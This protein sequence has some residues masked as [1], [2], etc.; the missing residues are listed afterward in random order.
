MGFLFEEIRR[1]TKRNTLLFLLLFGFLLNVANAGLND[2]LIAHYP[3]DGNAQ[4]VVGGF[5]GTMYST[6]STSDRNS[7]S[8]KALYFNG[9]N[10]WVTLP[11]PEQILGPNPSEY[12]VT[13]WFR[14]SSAH[15]GIIITQY[16]DWVTDHEET[17]ALHLNVV[18]ETM[19][20]YLR[21]QKDMG[22]VV[23]SVDVVNVGAWHHFAITFSK[24][25]GQIQLYVNGNFQGLETGFSPSV[26]YFDTEPLYLGK[27]I[28]KDANSSLFHGSLDDIKIY[29]RVLTDIEIGQSADMSVNLTTGLVSHYSFDG[30][31]QNSAGSY[32]H[33]IEQ[34]GVSY[35][36]GKF[37]QAA[38]FD[39]V[40]DHIKVPFHSALKPSYHSMSFWMKTNQTTWTTPYSSSYGHSS[41]NNSGVE[42]LLNY[43][44]APGE[45]VHDNMTAP[46]GNWGSRSN[47]QV[48]DGN[49]HHI[50]AS[51]DGTSSTIYVD[52]IERGSFNVNDYPQ[53]SAG[54][55]YW[56]APYPPYFMFGYTANTRREANTSYFQGQIDEFRLYS[57]PINANE[58]T[59]LSLDGLVGAIAVKEATPI[60]ETEKSNSE[61]E[62]ANSCFNIKGSPGP[63]TVRSGNYYHTHTDFTLPAQGLPLTITRYYNNQD[64]YA[65]PFGHNWNMDYTAQLVMTEDDNGDAF[66]TVRLGNGVRRKFID[67]GDGTFVAPFGQ[68][69]TLYYDGNYYVFNGECGVGCT[70]KPRKSY[71]FHDLEGSLAAIQDQN[72]TQVTIGYNLDG[73]IETVTDTNGRQITFAYGANGRVSTVSDFD[74]RVWTYSYDLED[75]LT[76]VAD[77]LEQTIQYQYDTNHN[78][79]AIIDALGNTVSTVSYD[80]S[81]RVVQ[82]TDNGGDYN[83]SHDP[84]SKVT[85]K[86]NP[87]AGNFRF[88]Y[89]DNGNI[90]NKVGP[91]GQS[92]NLTWDANVDM[93]SKV[94]GLSVQT[95]Y[96]YYSDHSVASVTRDATGLALTTSYTYDPVT[97]KVAQVTDPQTNTTSYIYDAQGNLLEQHTPIGTTLYEYDIFGNVTKVTDPDGYVTA[98]EYDTNGYMTRE[99]IPGTEPV[100]ETLYT[101]DNRGNL[102]TKTDPEGHTTTYVYDL[103]NQL[104]SVTDPLN[105]VSTFEYD[106]NG[107]MTLMTDALSRQTKFD[108]DLYDRLVTKT[109]DFG[110]SLERQTTYTYDTRGNL[111]TTTDPLNHTTTNAYD[112]LSRLISVTDELS[113]IWV[114]TYDA[115]GN[116]ET[117]TDPNS[118]TTQYLYDALNRLIGV[119]DAESLVTSYTYDGNGRLLTVLNAMSNM[120]T[121]NTYD[122]N[123]RLATSKDALNHTTTTTYTAGGRINTVTDANGNV[124]TYN[125][126][127]LTGRLASIVYGP[128]ART[129]TYV[130]DK[131]GRLLSVSDDQT[132]F[133]VVYTYDANGKVL[134]DTQ[135]GQVISYSYD[136]VGNR[137]TMDV[138]GVGQYQYGYDTLNR[139]SSILNPKA[140]QTTFDYNAADLRTGI[141]YA[142]GFSTTYAFDEVNRLTS[143][144]HTSDLGG[145]V[146][147][148]AYTYDA[149]NNRQSETDHLGNTVTYTYDKTYKLLSAV[150]PGETISFIYDAVGNRLSRTDNTET[151]TYTYDDADRLTNVDHPDGSNT[152]YTWDSNGNLQTTY[153]T[154]IGTPTNFY[155]S[156]DYNYDSK[157]QLIQITYDGAS[158]VDFRYDP[159]GRRLSST[160]KGSV[161]RFLYD[162]QNPVADILGDDAV[163]VIETIYTQGL[164]LDDLISNSKGVSASRYLLRDG[165]NSVRAVVAGGVVEADY[166]YNPYGSSRAMNGETINDFTYT[167]RRSVG[168][169]GLMY[170]RSRY[171]SPEVGRFLKKDSYE[172]KVNEPLSLNRFNYVHSNP[173]N[174]I[175]PEGEFAFLVLG[176]AMASTAAVMSVV[177]LVDVA[178]NDKQ[179][180]WTD[181]SA[182]TAGGAMMPVGVF[183]GGLSG[184]PAGAVV[185][186]AMFSG[187]T[188]SAIYRL[189]GDDEKAENA[190]KYSL[191]SAFIDTAGGDSTI[192][193]YMDE[194]SDA[195]SFV[196]DYSM[197]MDVGDICR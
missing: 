121:T 49:W 61:G 182:A 178:V 153:E 180:D 96:T 186:G 120:A 18:D 93:T 111:L 90:S 135:L 160:A 175:D 67:N 138:Q 137:L 98:R 45:L 150:Y 44:T 62:A 136:D 123:G 140:E 14:T 147:S 69:D 106:A 142:N 59:L 112:E 179:W 196:P 27:S 82:F 9:A 1:M 31:A 104:I 130:Y 113:Q 193:N 91:Q 154:V 46:T 36:N 192:V 183:L 114:M 176:A 20:T 152:V 102:L 94:N 5:H 171:Y 8:G 181:F 52:G 184:G 13:G 40:N 85:Q 74:S 4:D 34:N 30:H 170:Y 78:M 132:T 65:G 15:T 75:N 95:D 115:S 51:F 54:P 158:T 48:N 172:G 169:S 185:G 141:G 166:T 87:A 148:F 99:Y 17:F 173:V 70:P 53:Y 19:N 3:L 84:I 124:R 22:F 28:W 24:V 76:S 126:E 43:P 79:T 128:S 165:L 129:E 47:V 187:G 151:I 144:T 116:L 7:N 89:D 29:N 146:A 35:T 97:G 149:M 92:L 122:A 163:P 80:S 12:T 63:V 156:T 110:G 101:Y 77:P 60:N 58:V 108:Y 26:D 143:V 25:T 86:T 190:L 16:N 168:N 81:D 68:D 64:L 41:T 88:D 159:V 10:S 72:G 162:G 189:N 155:H 11:N 32:G 167:G 195:S 50:A 105:K 2:G 177:Y 83:I 107:N 117:K 145:T 188:S 42:M 23:P 109:E 127:P 139:L 37:G 194:S 39:G 118:N 21:Q 119:A 191:I 133:S 197:F 38:D 33:G 134:T 125:Y 164:G 6:A 174:F 161:R 57:R 103:L 56:A 131:A 66:A 71:L 55:M 73:R 157:K 100:I